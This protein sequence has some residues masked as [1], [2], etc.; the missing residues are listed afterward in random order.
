MV[1]SAIGLLS[2]YLVFLESRAIL[3]SDVVH[4]YLPI[5]RELVKA[6]EFTYNS[7]YDYNILLKPIGVSILYAWTYTVS[8][9]ILTEP[10]RLMPLTPIFML[11]ILNYAI[12]SSATK[13][14]IVSIISTAIFLILP[15][16]DR[17]LLYS[18]FYPDIFYYP[19]I[20]AAIY[21]L[22]EY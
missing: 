22:L 19:L 11:I 14:K 16:H 2:I 21:F 18:A 20:F 4:Y 13:S 12:T 3:D 1:I 10:F 15:F 7:G 9:S 6:N 17:F 5:A 8:G